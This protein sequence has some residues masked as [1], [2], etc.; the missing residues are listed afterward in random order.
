MKNPDVHICFYA[1]SSEGEIEYVQIQGKA[2]VSED[3]ELK[4][5]IWNPFSWLYY[6]CPEDSNY[7]VITVKPCR[8]ELWNMADLKKEP[9]PVAVW[10]P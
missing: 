10:E 9:K 2:E 3:P 8:A 6:T 1:Q 4:K 5:N 7:V